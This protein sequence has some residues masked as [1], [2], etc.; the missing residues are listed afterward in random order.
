MQN[1][2]LKNASP[3]LRV[4]R[5]LQGTAKIR[6]IYELFQNGKKG[7][8]LPITFIRLSQLTQQHKEDYAR[9]RKTHQHRCKT[10]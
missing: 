4:R 6:K 10:P 3:T 5:N 7:T 1:S 8:K 2:S 9:K